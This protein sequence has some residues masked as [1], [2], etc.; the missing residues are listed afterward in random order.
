ME[1]SNSLNICVLLLHMARS[2]N[3]FQLVAGVR[4]PWHPASEAGAAA[5]RLVDR[6]R[7]RIVAHAPRTPAHSVFGNRGP[8]RRS[9]FLPIGFV[10][11]LDQI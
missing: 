2:R 8:P 4:A 5:G 3:P 6:G 1:L 10:L 11:Q 9:R 7:T